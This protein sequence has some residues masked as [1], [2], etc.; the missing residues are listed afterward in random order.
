MDIQAYLDEDDYT[1]QQ[2][3]LKILADTYNLSIP[4]VRARLVNMGVYKN[5]P[6]QANRILKSTY[7]D[8]LVEHLDN[9][10][11]TDYEY[12]ER[13]TVTLLKKLIKATQKDENTLHER[14]TL[15]VSSPS[16]N[17]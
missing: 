12:L 10:T 7:V 17:I 9:I 4:K 8:T 6:K 13:L 14:P 16:E 5:K 15:G 3:Q 1:G 2:E 11:E